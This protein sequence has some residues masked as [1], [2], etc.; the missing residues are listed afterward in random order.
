[1]LN[2]TQF[3]CQTSTM[4]DRQIRLEIAI[5]NGQALNELIETLCNDPQTEHN[6][7]KL[8][9]NEYAH[10]EAYSRSKH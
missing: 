7:H 10:A 4:D 2:Y 1:M 5:L 6:Q 3:Y 8:K 9:L